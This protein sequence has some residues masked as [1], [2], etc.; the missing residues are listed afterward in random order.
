MKRLGVALALWAGLS[1][2]ALAEE[3]LRSAK[4][5]WDVAALQAVPLEVE[6]GEAVGLTRP[7]WYAGPS[8]QGRATRVFAWLGEPT[9]EVAG[10]RP[11]VLLVHGGGGQAFQEWARHWAERGYV[12]LAMDTAGQGPE[13]KRHPQGGPG[14]G[15]ETKFLPLEEAGAKESWTYHAV[16][17]VLRGHALLAARSEVDAERIG[18]TG[19][20]WGGYLTCLVAGLDARLK[21]AVPVYGCGFLGDNSYWRDR[22]LAA[23][24]LEAR[25]RWLRLFDPAQVI[26]EARGAVML[27]NGMHDF[28]YPP[29]S[30]GKT[31]RLVPEARRQWSLRADMAH[32]HIWTFPEV[33]AFL[34]EHLR[35]GSVP[36]VRLGEL[37]QEG[38]VVS[39]AVRPGT[40]A[41]RG[42]LHFTADTGAWQNRR[43]ETRPATVSG[44]EL[45][46]NLPAVRPLAYFM[47]AVD[48]RGLISSSDCQEVGAGANTATLPRDRLEEDFYDWN[49][50]HEAVKKAGVAA[51]PELVFV[52]DSITHLWGGVPDEPRGNRGREAWDRLVAGR[53]ALNVGFGW[54]RTQNVLWRMDHG[55]LEGLRPKHVVV[56][57]GTNNLVGTAQAREN[58]AAEIAEGIGAV[59]RR[60]QAKCPGARVVLM[61]LLPRGAGPQD[62]MRARVA[63][64]NARLPEVAKDTGSVL[65]DIGARLC[66]ADGSISQEMMP[67]GLHPGARGYAV[68]AEALAPLLGK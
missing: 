1:F 49:Q 30:H 5:L 2:S 35:P 8:Y 50:R 66:E 65:L 46:A 42:A 34:D 53:A 12:A 36:L 21:A 4:S 59:V 64:V 9:G 3:A 29:D 25:E 28:A 6:Y 16:A 38:D 67:D 10:K 13:G 57:I 37:R 41:T 56:L 18:I 32:G 31:G 22:S 54:D 47:E 48:A 45:T 33:D 39:V 20:S 7:V 23:L 52:G 60:V 27:V 24:P 14:Q 51:P 55:E 40:A 19:I 58:T 17:A 63:A 61:A 15:D 26:G 62:A 11:A 43:W 68:W 44:S